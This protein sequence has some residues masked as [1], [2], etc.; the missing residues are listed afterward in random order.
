MTPIIV[1]ALA[2]FLFLGWGLH[3]ATESPPGRDV[4]GFILAVWALPVAFV[5]RVGQA[6]VGIITW[7]QLWEDVKAVPEILGEYLD[8]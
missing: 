4:P 5:L 1:L 2:A 7:R 6:A 3:M 8:D